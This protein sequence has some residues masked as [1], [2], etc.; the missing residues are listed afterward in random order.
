MVFQVE[1]NARRIQEHRR[2]YERLHKEM[3]LKYFEHER[4]RKQA[5]AVSRVNTILL[6]LF[7]INKL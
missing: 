1:P 5:E 2:K 4:Q 6:L 7:C 3:E